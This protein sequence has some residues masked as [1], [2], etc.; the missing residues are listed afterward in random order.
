MEPPHQASETR[1][2]GEA[3]LPMA[4]STHVAR[5][6]SWGHSREGMTGVA[7]ATEQGLIAAPSAATLHRSP[8]Y[9]ARSSSKPGFGR[10]SRIPPTIHRTSSRSETTTRRFWGF[11][12]TAGN[13]SQGAGAERQHEG[14]W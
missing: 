14:A 9:W 2:G 4:W 3:A 7:K 5:E 10:I 1:W 11:L 6:D 8:V 12:E 13:H